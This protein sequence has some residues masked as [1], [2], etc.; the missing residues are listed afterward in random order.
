MALNGTDFIN[1]PFNTSFS[2]FTDF[3]ENMGMNGMLF[4][5]FP[6]M[7]LVLAIYVKTE[8]PV[9]ASMSM[10]VSGLLLGS[11]GMFI[12]SGDVALVF[13]I[14]AALGIAA[15]LLSVFFQRRQ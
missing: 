3:F 8:D 15:V 13:Y 6:L 11:G 9:V 10:I 1:D 14:F 12:G 4:F 2:P 5:L 7:I